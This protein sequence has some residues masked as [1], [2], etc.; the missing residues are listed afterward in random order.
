[1]A[2]DKTLVAIVKNDNN[3][4]VELE[5]EA[6][7]YDVDGNSLGSDTSY[8]YI[9]KN[10]E[11]ACDFYNVPEN[12]NDYEINIKASE[13][14]YTNYSDKVEIKDNDTGEQLAVQV[15]NNAGKDIDSVDV[16]VVFYQ[17]DKIV[18]FGS[19]LATDLREGQTSTSNIYYPYDENYD[20]ITYD[21]YKVFVSA[22]NLEI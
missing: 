11:M 5:V 3:S 9:N 18:G 16:A 2:A 21:S 6:V 17:G 12:Y 10:Q 19:D 4:A 14:I 15:T 7:F 1:M 22:Y 20:D 8:L 13:P